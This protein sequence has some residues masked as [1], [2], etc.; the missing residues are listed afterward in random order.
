MSH[1]ARW[2]DRK[3]RATR[4]NSGRLIFGRADTTTQYAVQYSPR[5]AKPVLVKPIPFSVGIAMTVDRCRRVL[6][7]RKDE[8]W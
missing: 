3:I 4:G 6:A 1:K 5:I 2:N 8:P 7:L